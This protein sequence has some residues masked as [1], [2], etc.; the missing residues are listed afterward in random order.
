MN[1]SSLHTLAG[2]ALEVSLSTFSMKNILSEHSGRKSVKSAIRANW[3]AY[4][5]CLG[6]SSNVEL[7]VGRYLNWLMTDLPDYFINLV[8]CN[9]LP[10]KGVD[11]LVESALAHFR[12]MNIKKLSWLSHEDVPS[13]EIYKALLARGLTFK[14]SFA[15]EMAVDLSSLPEDLPTHPDLRIV[16]VVDGSALK[17]WIHVASVGF[18][19]SEKYEKVW[20]DFFVDAIFNPQFRTYLA[21]L[22][23]KPVGTSQVFLSEGVAGIYNVT[24]IPEARGKGIGSAITLTPLLK[25]REMGYRIGILQ[26]S[27]QGYNVYRRLGFQDFGNL[28]LY[29]WEN[30][31]ALM[32]G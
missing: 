27:K 21:L 32:E 23:G 8:V 1:S 22:N 2:F 19:I 15:T 24:C 13:T 7:S 25:A 10:S 29:L 16:S 4:H 12:S 6:R 18:R 5:Y 31:R 30:N 28:S 26:A 17:Q 3:E 14:E 20:Y 9:Q 11:D